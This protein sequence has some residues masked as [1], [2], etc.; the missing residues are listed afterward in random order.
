MT[1]SH[2]YDVILNVTFVIRIMMLN[3]QHLTTWTILR[4]RTIEVSQTFLF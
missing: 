3:K 2:F 4:A 1:N